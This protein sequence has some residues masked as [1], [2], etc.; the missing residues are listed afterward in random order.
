MKTKSEHVLVAEET[1]SRALRSLP[2]RLPPP[3]LASSLRVIASRECLRALGREIVFADRLRLCFD[4]LMRPLALPFAGGIF[5]TIILFGMCLVPVYSVHA[6]STAD[7]PTGLHTD[8]TLFATPPI[9]AAPGDVI[10]D[11]TID[12]DG[13]MIDY[14]IVSGNVSRN[15]AL[16]RSIEGTLLLTRFTPATAFGQPVEGRMRLSLRTS[17]IDVR[18]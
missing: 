18:G 8:A 10:V 9:A 12:P 3:E 4:N 17:H 7:V 13:R 6:S 11:V 15:E 1:L 2:R 16:I 5:S 14:K